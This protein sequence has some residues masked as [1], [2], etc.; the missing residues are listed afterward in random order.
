LL[1]IGTNRT[2][3]ALELIRE[4]ENGW[5]IP[6]ENVDALYQSMREATLLPQDVWLKRSSAA[7]IS[8]KNHA[9]TNGVSRFQ[10]A[11]EATLKSYRG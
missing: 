1:V 5:L 4:Q 7:E 11:V 3:A 2:G 9:I 8:V 10:N 6:S